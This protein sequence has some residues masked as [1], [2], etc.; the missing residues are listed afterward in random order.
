MGPQY[1]NLH[2]ANSK[3]VADWLVLCVVKLE[4]SLRSLGPQWCVLRNE[5]DKTVRAVQPQEHCAV[6]KLEA[7]VYGILPFCAS[8]C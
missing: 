1:E 5:C 8:M 3:L 7:L 2:P 6:Y 4:P